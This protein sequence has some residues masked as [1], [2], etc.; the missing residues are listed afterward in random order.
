[1]QQRR[2]QTSILGPQIRQEVSPGYESR[3]MSQVKEH[4]NF[5]SDSLSSQAKFQKSLAWQERPSTTR[6]GTMTRKEH[7]LHW[8]TYGQAFVYQLSFQ[9]TRSVWLSEKQLEGKLYILACGR[10]TVSSELKQMTI[11]WQ[12]VNDVTRPYCLL[13]TKPLLLANFKAVKWD[14]LTHDL[15]GTGWPWLIWTAQTN[16][17]RALLILFKNCPFFYVT[18]WLCL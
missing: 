13:P 5:S 3:N 11:D 1:M 2:L 7:Y 6:S 15:G 14:T 12:P 10:S 18:A 16:R 4:L 8:Q 9:Q 17:K